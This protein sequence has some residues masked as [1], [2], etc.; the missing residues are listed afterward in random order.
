[1]LE[2]DSK[3]VNIVTASGNYRAKSLSARKQRT[4]TKKRIP[5][6][7]GEDPLVTVS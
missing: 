6:I 7:E 5:S 2:V 3:Q 4:R 1:M